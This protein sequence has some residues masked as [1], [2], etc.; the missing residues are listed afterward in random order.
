MAEFIRLLLC[1]MWRYLK[2]AETAIPELD[3]K[4]HAGWWADGQIDDGSFVSG[5]QW[6]TIK[7][8]SLQYTDQ[9]NRE[10]VLT[11]Q[12]QIWIKNIAG[13]WADGQIE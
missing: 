10:Q 3:Q 7:R 4:Q 11:M 2:P 9:Q 6:L 1:L 13:W 5:I 12:F 8:T